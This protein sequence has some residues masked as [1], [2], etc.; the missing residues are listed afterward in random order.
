MQQPELGDLYRSES[1]DHLERLGRAVLAIERG[2]EKG[3]IDEAFRAAHTLKGMS[4]SMGHTSVVS[5]AHGLEHL[6]VKIRDGALAVDA[7][8][9]DLL[10]SAVDELGRVVEGVLT[11]GG[12]SDF[13][14]GVA[15]AGA[16]ARP[17]MQSETARYVR[18]E[19]DRIDS[20]M[21]RA[22][23][24]VVTRE[25]LLRLAREAENPEIEA[26]ANDLGRAFV[27]LR[28]DALRLRLAPVAELSD[29]LNRLVRDG[30]RSLGKEVHLQLIGGHVEIDRGLLGDLLELLTHL[31]R[32]SLDHGIEPATE[33]SAAGKAPVG[34]IRVAATQSRDTVTV[35]V[36]DDGRGIDRERV[37]RQAAAKGLRPR[38]RSADMTA[39]EFLDLLVLPGFSTATEVTELSGRGV[40]LD[41]VASRLR[42]LGGDLRLKT[43]QGKGAAFAIT[44]PK[45]LSLTRV[46]LVG[47]G[48]E[49][50]AIPLAAVERVEDEAS[51][52]AVSDDVGSSSSEGQKTIIRG[53]A[54]LC[55]YAPIAR[56][57]GKG[58]LVVVGKGSRRV[59]FVVD[60]LLGFQD[61]VIKQF[62]VP[63]GMLDLYA[64]ATI[65]PDGL[66]RL[67][68]DPGRLVAR[69]EW[70]HSRTR[71][72]RT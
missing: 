65:L 14:T 35:R 55:G 40:G 67:V 21:N 17:S 39:A 16:E 59:K 44:L 43:E 3:A 50:L 63:R 66:P 52:W 32:N 18:V 41:H 71:T 20:L 38:G 8:V 6:L 23:E 4:A 30:S 72:A 33:R 9:I 12:Y 24:L 46:L 58:F 60:N 29:R 11:N 28:D 47:C 57:A 68:L 64:G 25:R 34:R 2:A 49:L 70:V 56:S 1:R 26:L 45:T 54:D 7:Q 51:G 48:H 31:I 27:E 69:G 19:Q 36:E 5:L 42:E 53:L 10:L 62:A 22:G 15:E 13:D 61:V 37:V